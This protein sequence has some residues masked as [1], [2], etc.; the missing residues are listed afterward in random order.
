MKAARLLLRPEEGAFP[1]V[2][3]ALAGCDHLT[4]EQLLN[5]EWRADRSSALLYRLSVGGD[6]DR[7]AR[8]AAEA[9][10]AGHAE[11]RHHEVV[12]AGS[13]TVYAFVHVSEREP[14][15]ELLAIVERH[16]LLLDL[17]F[18]FT[19]EGVSVTVAG[20]AGALQRAFGE[21]S[22]AID[23]DVEWSG[24][25]RPESSAPLARLTDRQREAL[26]VAYDLGFYRTPRTV[27]H[28]EIADALDCAPSTAN[29]LLRRAEATLVGA[30]LDR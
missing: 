3:R 26:G 13:G 18:T 20:D 25:Y 14:L 10:L 29:E 24:G 16:A 2:D 15:S 6:G 1:G 19:E 7:D 23:V 8:A 9:V 5:L 12:D 11:V 22:D 4:R 30:V 28:E 27:T 17:P 21:A